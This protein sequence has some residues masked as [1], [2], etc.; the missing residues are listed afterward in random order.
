MS[1]ITGISVDDECISVFTELKIGHKYRFITFTFSADLK[2][3][4]IDQKGDHDKTYDDFLD[5]LPP[6]DV[7]YAVY[8]FDYISEEGTPR[9]K[10]V[11][12]VWAPD[13]APARKKMVIAG[14]K[15]GI[16]QALNG[17]AIEIQANDDQ[18]ISEAVVKEKCISSS[19]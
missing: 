8:D 2:K 14:T 1:N 16:K 13:T 15:G 17:V 9:N 3:I 10:V 18:G 11:F 4:I 19:Y 12:I 7:R 5:I 6:K